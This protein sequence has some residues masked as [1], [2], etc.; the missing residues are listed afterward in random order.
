VSQNDIN[1][2]MR[3]NNALDEGKMFGQKEK[4]V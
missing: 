2:N 1:S 3:W 4:K